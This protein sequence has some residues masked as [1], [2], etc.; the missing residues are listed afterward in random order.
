MKV[1][2]QDQP[3]VE[4]NLIRFSGFK[5]K[6]SVR[7]CFTQLLQKPKGQL[8]YIKFKINY[9]VRS[10]TNPGVIFQSSFSFIYLC[11]SKIH[12]VLWVWPK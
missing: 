5:R 10:Y 6:G 12:V 4:I 3:N 8:N 7:Y 9:V 11:L 2:T 1:P